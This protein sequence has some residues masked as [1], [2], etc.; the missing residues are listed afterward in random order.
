L[1][2]L[3]NET[4]ATAYIEKGYMGAEPQYSLSDAAIAMLEPKAIVL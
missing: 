4:I 3:C 2:P 1:Q